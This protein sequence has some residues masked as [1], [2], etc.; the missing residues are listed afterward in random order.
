MFLV[1]Y[2]DHFEPAA[3]LIAQKY[4]NLYLLLSGGLDSEFVLSVFLHMGMDIKPVIMNL[5]TF[6]GINYNYFESK[7]AYE[8]C[9]SKK[10]EVN[11]SFTVSNFT[12]YC[13]KAHRRHPSLF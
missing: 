4:K 13:F 2:Q 10:H 12:L 6:D 11:A 7:Y 1:T 8:Y 3:K 9:K 5:N